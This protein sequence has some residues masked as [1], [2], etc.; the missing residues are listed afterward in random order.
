[1]SS[2]Q[3]RDRPIPGPGLSNVIVPKGQASCK[4]SI[5]GLDPA[6]ERPLST[7]CDI[8][9]PQ[10]PSVNPQIPPDMLPDALDPPAG[11]LHYVQRLQNHYQGQHLSPQDSIVYTL[12][13]PDEARNSSG[14]VVR[15]VYVATLTLHNF[16]P[17]RVYKGNGV[18]KQAAKESAARAAISDLRIS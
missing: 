6:F 7:A 14:G 10:A 13:G 16:R 11:G 4:Y 18:G 5:P 8:G 15:D 2:A 12:H 9:F 17:P 1:M 3:V